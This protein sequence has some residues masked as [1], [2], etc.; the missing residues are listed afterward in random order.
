MKLQLLQLFFAMMTLLVSQAQAF[1]HFLW[2][3]VPAGGEK[4]AAAEIYFA[5]TAEPGEA[6]LVSK[7]AGTK[8]WLRTAAHAEAQ[9]I[10]LKKV[11]NDSEGKLVATAAANRTYAVEAVCDYG[12][13]AKGEKPFLLQYYAKYLATASNDELVKLGKSS[14]LPLDIQPQLANDAV[15]LRVTWNE[16]PLANAEV[17]VH[18][19]GGDSL[20][21]KTN[22]DGEVEVRAKERGLYAIRARHIENRSGD[23]DG[24]SYDQVR[25][26]ATLTLA[27]PGADSTATAKG[28]TAAELLRN[29]R[30]ARAVWNDLPGFT[31]DIVVH[32]NDERVEGKLIVN[33][34]GDVT[35]KTPE[36]A[37]SEWLEEYLAS[38]MQ[39]RMPE[40]PRNE[41]VRYVDDGDDHPL[42]RKIALG[43][44]QQDSIYRIKGDVVAEV[45]RRAGPNRFTISVLEVTRNAENKYLPMYYTMTFWD[46]EGQVVS[47]STTHDTWTRVGNFDLPLKTVQVTT[48]KDRRDVKV[49]EFKNH[50]LHEP[51]TTA[52]G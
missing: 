33:S 39:H 48:G 23:R 51:E 4:P 38:V 28:Q 3:N 32:F 8:A 10:S 9:P 37:G 31:T 40:G 45:N 15:R 43:D 20:D 1:G 22:E 2:L 27:L 21:N 17:V 24:K 29:A 25:H 41:D 6:H 5:E 42:G 46:K 49:L 30:E 7:I 13:V 47:S 12:V 18:F 11:E 50:R 52:G 34:D 36:F 44:G 26:Y 16:T 19:P 14:R 35:I